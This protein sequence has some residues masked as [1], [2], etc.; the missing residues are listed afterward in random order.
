MSII[1]YAKKHHSQLF[2]RPSNHTHHLDGLRAISCL[3]II[4]YHVFFLT[5]LFVPFETF[6]EFLK[7]TPTYY[8][9]IWGLDKTV[10]SFFVISG[11]LIG[12]I[13]LKEMGKT[14]T[15]SLGNFYWRRYL[16]LTPVY[17]LAIFIFYLV[18]PKQQSENIWANIFYI[19][20]FLPF[21]SMSM[22]WTWSLAVEEQFY[23]L[24]PLLLLATKALSPSHHLIRNLIG[25]SLA[26]FLLS[27][28][29]R[30]LIVFSNETISTSG[31]SEL[32]NSR[33]GILVYF[34]SIY[35]NLHTRFGPFIL[36]FLA[37]LLLQHKQ[38]NMEL[39]FK[40]QQIGYRILTQTITF[41]ALIIIILS[42]FANGNKHWIGSAEHSLWFLICDRNL[43][44]LALTWILVSLYFPSGI[45]LLIKQ[46]L[47]AKIFYPL[48]QLSYSLYLFHYMLAI[49]VVFS[50]VKTLE[51]NY[52]LG[53][54][55]GYHWYFLATV[56]LL[57]L[58][59]PVSYLIYITIERPFI[60]LRPS[61]PQLS[62]KPP[63]AEGVQRV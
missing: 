63:M 61:S 10:D 13:L 57:I 32:F 35:V 28:F 22:P 39:F 56:I 36:G 27:F 41:L 37:A 15:L 48:A 12:Q 26:L 30:A 33:A 59:L 29:V 53:V 11:F 19:N 2:Q 1:K 52:E 49:P 40:N 43:F 45:G 20:N 17:L 46:F 60:D 23:L 14:G 24:L 9:W 31:Y 42:L 47:S 25:V 6:N 5:S 62:N 7:N 16:R 8:S 18:A 21:E 54:L 50:L 34:D 55:A 3:L 44:A 58:C 4:L 51:A 38:H